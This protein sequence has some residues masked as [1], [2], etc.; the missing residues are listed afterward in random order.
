M[1]YRI[2]YI[3]RVSLAAFVAVAAYFDSTITYLFALLIAFTFNIIAGFR[4]DEV[5]FT[6]QRVFPPFRFQNFQKNK[7]KDSLIELLL[8]TVITYILKLLIELLK[9]E[10]S[11]AYVVQ[12]LLAI[13]VYYY[14][15]NALRNFHKAYP[16]IRF[17]SLVYHLMSFK[18]RAII[19]N[20]IADI[21]DKEEKLDKNM[22]DARENLA[23]TKESMNVVQETLNLIK[24]DSHDKK[25]NNTES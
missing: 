18:F 24:K 25:N 6:I 4:A 8:I 3:Q 13:A 7:F 14:F 1:P 19:G 23:K 17:I 10:A 20:D 2:D 12:Y 22:D 5:K 11:G 21:I 9:Y 15:R 16:K